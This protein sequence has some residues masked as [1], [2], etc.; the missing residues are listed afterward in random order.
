L[1]SAGNDGRVLAWT[2]RDREPEPESLEVLAQHTGAVTALAVA[3]DAVVSA[4]RDAALIR[5]GLGAR[6][7]TTLRDEAKALALTDDGWLYAVT[8]TGAAVRWTDGAAS[9]EIEHGARGVAALPASRI[10]VALD[11]GAIVI[12]TVQPRSLAELAATLAHATSY[13]LPETADSPV[14]EAVPRARGA[15]Q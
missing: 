2:I 1:F 15:D 6:A 14:A 13:A 12:R 4:G 9:V 10:A 7:A 3:R 5:S 8:R 11:D